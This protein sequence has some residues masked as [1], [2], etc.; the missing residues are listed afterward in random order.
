MISSQKEDWQRP[1]PDKLPRP[2]YWPAFL[3]FGIVSSLSGI[4]TSWV[5]ASVGGVV[6]LIGL[7]G[8]I[9]ELRHE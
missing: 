2:T 3:A 4:V 5:V 7:I 8:W 6:F 1:K 9:G